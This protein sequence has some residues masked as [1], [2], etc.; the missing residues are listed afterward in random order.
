MNTLKRE[1]ADLQRVLSSAIADA[2]RRSALIAHRNDRTTA[3]ELLCQLRERSSDP[4]AI[5][6]LALVVSRFP[7]TAEARSAADLLLQGHIHD[8]SLDSVFDTLE[9][10][11]SDLALEIL[12]AAFQHSPHSRVRGH[13]GFAL[14]C[15]LKTRGERDGWSNPI[16]SRDETAQARRHFLEIA[17][18]YGNLRKGRDRPSDLAQ[19]QLVEID[20]LSLDKVAPESEGEDDDGRPMRLTDYRGKVVVLAFWGNWCSLCRSMFPY[21]RSI[22]ERMRGRPFVMLGVNSDDQMS[23]PQSLARDGSVTWRSWRDSGALYGGAIT[24]R[25][26]VQAL[27]DLFILDDR[28]VIRHHVGPHADDH[29]RLYLLDSGGELQNRWQARASEVAEVAKAL[30]R[31]VEREHAAPRLF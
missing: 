27:P 29:D 24:R 12:R 11:E 8:E 18:S 22:V 9:Q 31:E 19:S 6:A 3:R 28:G 30:V 1:E 13:A 7:G 25:W 5:P 23:A 10:S 20:T 4:M 16:L 21:E 15:L 26:N 2:E 17:A 14:G